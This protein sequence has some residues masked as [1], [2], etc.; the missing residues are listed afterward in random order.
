MSEDYIAGSKV[1]G[2][3]AELLGSEKYRKVMSEGEE[4]IV[5]NAYITYGGKRCI[6]GRSSLQKKKDQSW[7][8]D[9]MM[10]VWDMLYEE[11]RKATAGIQMTPANI[12]YISTDGRKVDVETEISYHHQRPENKSVGRATGKNDGSGFYQ[13]CSI[14]AGQT[15][16]GYIYANKHQ[17]EVILDA[18]ERAGEIRMGY[19]RSSEF[20]A[21]DLVVDEIAEDKVNDVT[22]AGQYE[23]DKYVHDAVITLV[24]D[25]IL[26]NER[27]IPTTEI[28]EF[29]K[30]L[31]KVL[32]VED[33]E[34]A[35]GVSPY[36]KF[37]TTGGFNVTWGKRKPIHQTLGKGS[38]F[39]I[40]SDIG[41]CM[42]DLKDI[43]VGE[44]VSEGF[45]EILA[46]KQ[47]DAKIL[48]RKPESRDKSANV[49]LDDSEE[50]VQKLLLAEFGRRMQGTV[51]TCVKEKSKFYE[52]NK[53]GLNAAI[54][55]LRGIYRDVPDYQEMLSQVES[56]EKDD[57][58][59]LC[60]EIV[61]NVNP[62]QIKKMIEQEMLEEYGMR[63]V[64]PW[65]D[66]QLYKQT[67][68]AYI[69][70]LKYFVK[71]L[72]DHSRKVQEG[73][74]GNGRKL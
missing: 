47:R 2:V 27:G 74:E 40:H 69:T 33:I 1:L 48:V 31:R 44:R 39:M 3:I 71:K 35:N 24:S 11:S 19:G 9:G 17:A 64:L 65:S 53:N 34:L 55:K 29:V 61:R 16:S 67:Y 21:V 66:S 60:T 13:L 72:E 58:N 46:E 22:K 14:R 8:S 50:I 36:L 38:T 51:R 62:D 68:R 10:D 26:Y 6:P 49:A 59:K 45:G 15:F 57:K 4:L 25:A 12:D 32:R 5:S 56:I 70:E 73:G 43:F 42:E 18:L 52:Q 63:V 7:T 54:A 20:G 37:A 23:S 41:M 28:S 30:Y